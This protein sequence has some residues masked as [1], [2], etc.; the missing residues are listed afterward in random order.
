MM[1]MQKSNSYEKKGTMEEGKSVVVQVR[2]FQN[3]VFAVQSKG[4]NLPQ[5]FV[6]D[7]RTPTIFEGLWDPLKIQ[8][9]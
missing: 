6:M 5:E 1:F 7:S 8:E 2:E 3:I 4:M 9:K